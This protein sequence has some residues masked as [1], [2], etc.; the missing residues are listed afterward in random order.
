MLTRPE[1]AAEAAG[2]RM[3]IPVETASIVMLPISTYAKTELGIVPHA[4]AR[5]F[6]LA[7]PVQP[8]LRV[9]VA[10]EYV[11][12][13][14]RFIIRTA[15]IPS[16]SLDFGIVPSALAAPLRPV[17]LLLLLLAPPLLLHHLPVP[18]WAIRVCWEHLT[19][20]VIIATLFAVV[21]VLLD[22]GVAMPEEHVSLALFRHVPPQLLPLQVQPV[23]NGAVREHTER[24]VM[25]RT[26]ITPSFIALGI[27]IVLN[28]LVCTAFIAI[29]ILI[30]AKLLAA[31]IFAG[32]LREREVKMINV[33]L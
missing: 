24:A 28:V 13:H 16:I 2:E 6:R 3:G 32:A 27:G 25:R 26:Q 21:I 33:M 18:I 20:S 29:I 7:P 15:P 22:F 19:P 23:L 14:A 10:L 1:I 4:L 17:P 8:E 31:G 5:P 30:N 9:Q 12:T 11:E